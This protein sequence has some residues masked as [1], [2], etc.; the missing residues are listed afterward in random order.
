MPCHY[1]IYPELN[2]ALFTYQGVLRANEVVALADMV[3]SDPL[4]TRT[5]NELGDFR[6]LEK[7]DFDANTLTNLSTLLMGL[8][9][10]SSRNKKISMLVPNTSL[11]SSA[12]TFASI[13]SAS[14]PISIRIFETLKPALGYLDLTP[15]DL[16]R[17]TP[18]LQD[19]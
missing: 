5:I 4:Y 17:E 2:L 6:N 9:L 8:Y 18:V 12:K 11:H 10:R 14:T 1:N 13:V 16:P 15:E 19:L 3:D 7:V